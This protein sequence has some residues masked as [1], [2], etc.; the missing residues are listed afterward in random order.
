MSGLGRINKARGLSTII[1][2]R[3]IIVEKDVLDI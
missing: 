1:Y 3:E 2:F